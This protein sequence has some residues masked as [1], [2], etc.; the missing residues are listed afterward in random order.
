[1]TTHRWHT[2]R[3]TGTAGVHRISRLGL[4][5]A[6]LVIEEDGLTLID[7]GLAGTHRLILAR[8]AALGMPIRRIA[9]T[10]AHR[11]HMGSL[12]ALAAA[13]PAAEVIASEREAALLAG[14][15]KLREHEPAGR[16]RGGFRAVATRPARLAGDGDQ[17]GSLRVL[18]TPGHTPGHLAFFDPRDGTLY[19]GDSFTTTRG[20][21]TSA[22]VP[23]RYPM[24]GLATWNRELD[25]ASARALRELDP[26]RLA[27]GHGPVIQTPGHA[28]DRAIAGAARK[29]ER[30]LKPR[31]R[32]DS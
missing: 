28:M 2:D 27:S 13:L 3:L 24:A 9:L 6:Y 14:D 25:L 4:V 23:W 26:A 7:T 17:I 31:S 18:A 32:A 19:A 1:M 11:D 21:A 22:V 12:D 15:T 20:V 16:M 5:N 29:L 30:S 10:H 8:A